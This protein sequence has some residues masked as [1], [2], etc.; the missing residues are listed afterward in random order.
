MKNENRILELNDT[1]KHNNI[2]IVRNPE[3]ER[4]KGTENLFEEIIAENFLNLGKETYLNLGGTESPQK[5]QP[6]VVHTKISC[7]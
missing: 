2:C 3:E 6:K 4:E 7:N 5:N 1:I